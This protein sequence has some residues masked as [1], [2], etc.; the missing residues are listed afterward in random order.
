M[1]IKEF[2]DTHNDHESCV[3]IDRNRGV[4]RGYI[5][6]LPNYISSKEVGDACEIHQ[7]NN[8]LTLSDWYCIHVKG[9]YE[10][11]KYHNAPQPFTGGFYI[12][13][14]HFGYQA[15]IYENQA[16]AYISDIYQTH[17]AVVDF[18]SDYYS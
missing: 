14:L 6:D 15:V 2:F 7:F 18:I 13:E 12:M 4:Y 8:D 3:I 5:T 10:L 17:A 9:L 11:N 16:T 1:T